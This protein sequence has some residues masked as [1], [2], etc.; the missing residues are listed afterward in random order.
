MAHLLAVSAHSDGRNV[1]RV[2]LPAFYTL[3]QISSKNQ[4]AVQLT[5]F[6]R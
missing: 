2:Q 6:G 4:P 1:T 5:R 3:D